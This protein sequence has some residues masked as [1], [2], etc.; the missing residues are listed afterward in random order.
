MRQRLQGHG[1]HGKQSEIS[2]T[3]WAAHPHR[4]VW[5]ALTG[6]ALDVVA[7]PDILLFPRTS[8]SIKFA[9]L[10]AP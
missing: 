2:I 7:V 10:A 3:L 6:A 9:A 1:I 8:M 4:R 5:G